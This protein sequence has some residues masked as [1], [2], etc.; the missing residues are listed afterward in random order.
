MARYNQYSRRQLISS[1]GAGAVGVT[2][3]TGGATAESSTE[4]DLEK[5]FV[6][7]K[8]K[9]IIKYREDEV[10]FDVKIHSE[11]LTKRYGYSYPSYNYTG[12]FERE[13]I[14]KED[15]EEIPRRGAEKRE[16]DW[17]A[18]I[19]KEDE[20]REFHEK[21]TDDGQGV[22]AQSGH[23]DDEKAQY[24]Y[25]TYKYDDDT[26]DYSL[27]IPCNIWTDIGIDLDECKSV[28]NQTDWYTQD[29]WGMRE[30]TRYTWDAWTG[31]M[32]SSDGPAGYSYAT[33]QSHNTTRR[34]HVKI[35]K[36]GPYREKVSMQAHEDTSEWDQWY[37]DMSAIWSYYWGR[38]QILDIFENHGYTIDKFAQDME[39]HKRPCGEQDCHRGYA[40]GIL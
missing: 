21:R 23:H 19:G 14:P 38:E 9:K 30:H 37:N 26:D 11:E 10:V 4:E 39:L 12:V 20:W 18:Y 35:W 15:R 28:M 40:H 8:K 16:Y 25:W 17:G 1:L 34:H 3:L 24:A 7:G 6:E 36:C 33:Q 32:L 27:T 13:E 22:G 31:S 29:S 5:L 2:A